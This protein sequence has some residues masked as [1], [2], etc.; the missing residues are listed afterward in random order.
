MVEFNKQPPEY[1]KVITYNMSE[2]ERAALE[3]RK[4]DKVEIS[5]FG[6]LTLAPQ[7]GMYGGKKYRRKGGE[8]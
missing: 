5:G 3:A 2:G 8:K 7:Q 1:G 4:R 6:L